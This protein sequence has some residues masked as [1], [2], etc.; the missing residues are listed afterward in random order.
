[1]SPNWTRKAALLLG[2]PAGIA[3]GSPLA[4][5]Q[6]VGSAQA[7]AASATPAPS[8][9]A[10]VNLVR[11]LVAQG[12]IAK[13][14]GD[15]LIAQALQEA[16]QAKLAEA[17]AHRALALV[18]TAPSGG[19][20]APALAQAGSGG[21]AAATPAAAA[22]APVEMAA[23]LPPPIN[24]AIRVPYIPQV[25][26]DQIRDD[27][28]ADVMREAR[29]QG[30]ASPGLAAPE[31]VRGMRIYGDLR[32]RSQSQLYSKF[33]STVIPN[34]QSIVSG[35][36][37]NLLSGA[38]PFLNTTAN[39]YSLMSVRARLGFDF[40][41]NSRTTVGLELASGN[42]NAPV[43][44]S[45]T[46]GNGF[47]KRNLYLNKAF[48]T[49]R[50]TPNFSVTVGRM[51]NPFLSNEALFSNELKF[52]GIAG[53][54]AMPNR[55][56][57]NADFFV[58]GGAFPLDFG[59]QNFPDT[60]TI[61]ATSGQKWLFAGQ[62]ETDWRLGNDRTLK[63]SAGY[64]MFKNITGVPSKAC[65][66]GFGDTQCST[67]ASAAFFVQ[68][69]N[70]LFQ[71]RD[72]V[73][74]AGQAV[75]GA[76]LLGLAER[77]RVLDA[78][79]V[80]KIPV[81][82]KTEVT[83]MGE[84]LRN[85]AFRRNVCQYGQ[86]YEPVNNGGAGGSGN[87]CDTVVANR[88]PFVGGGQGFQLLASIGNPAPKQ[89]GEWRAFLGYK[90]LE[91]DVVLDAFNDDS[92]HLGGTNAKGFTIGGTLALSPGVTLTPRWQSANQ[93]SGDPLAIDVFQLDLNVAF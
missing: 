72:I 71:I 79:A 23:N 65:A 77:F 74:S 29:A 68:K 34:F 39:K 92:F 12:T 63:L 57:G 44:T 90:Y 55:V 35:G 67:D 75:D 7:T 41:V 38:I 31:W 24:G 4:H 53:T 28:K 87:I 20:P 37:L 11:L 85:L 19:A 54:L 46:L 93:V 43:S 15:A 51:D 30:W 76:Q 64:Y 27:I 42:N 70:T 21:A 25:V 81:H 47:F 5:A 50:F 66:L 59:N 14:K 3:L 45:A 6:A 60:S 33:N 49:E 36:P 32:I 73:N 48:V 8:T 62:L 80:L 22:S 91:S 2:L 86:A 61:K 69:G 58:R 13:D 1:M 83:L 82:D 88:T 84:Y 26:R 10:M 52:D 18:Q 17:E 78:I 56:F 9:N 40:N 89:W 16:E